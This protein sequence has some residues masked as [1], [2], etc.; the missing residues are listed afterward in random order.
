M[1]TMREFISNALDGVGGDASQVYISMEDVMFIL[2]IAAGEFADCIEVR[3]ASKAWLIV[4]RI[5]PID[6]IA[7]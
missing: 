6:E 4:L 2:R 1:Y 7:I 5:T 3:L